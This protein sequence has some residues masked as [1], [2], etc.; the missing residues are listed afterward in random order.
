M[1]YN[2]L[3]KVLEDVGLD[4]EFHYKDPEKKE[5]DYVFIDKFIIMKA[6][7]VKLLLD[8]V[9]FK[10]V[11]CL[12]GEQGINYFKERLDLI[13]EL[14][15]RD[16]V[17]VFDSS[18]LSHSRTMKNDTFFKT[19]YLKSIFGPVACSKLTKC[20][21]LSYSDFILF[22]KLVVPLNDKIS[23]DEIKM[24]REDMVLSPDTWRS[25]RKIIDFSSLSEKEIALIL[26]NVIDEVFFSDCYDG[27]IFET[28]EDHE[29]FIYNIK[30]KEEDKFLY[31]IRFN[32][33]DRLTP[34][35][36]K[37]R[38]EYGVMNRLDKNKVVLTPDVIRMIA[39][40]R[41]NENIY[42]D[43]WE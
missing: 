35:F 28:T 4:C 13:V 36:V 18:K 33:F 30:S 2:Y 16:E 11:Y 32:K 15:K 42:A 37:Y 12:P 41:C 21:E 7:E 9:D 10:R 27:Y 8:D 29:N 34:V 19:Y 3:K 26:N 39:K 17:V 1:F 6:D 40:H 23:Q 14:F 22:D 25:K 31:S 24:M 43:G 38:T 20:L 5:L